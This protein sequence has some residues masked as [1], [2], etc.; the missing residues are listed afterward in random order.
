MRSPRSR[1]PLLAPLRRMVAAQHEHRARLNGGLARHQQ[2]WR[3]R[4]DKAPRIPVELTE[5]AHD[6]VCVAGEANA[7]NQSLPGAHPT[8]LVHWTACRVA[9]GERFEAVLAHRYPLAPSTP[10]HTGLELSILESGLPLAE[11]VRRWQAF[12][13][14]GDVVCS[15]GTFAVELARDARLPLPG[16]LLDL[17]KVTGDV[18]RISPG[19]VED[20][21][22][23]WSLDASAVG[24]GRAGLR[25][26]HLVRVARHLG[27]L[28]RP[29]ARL[30]SR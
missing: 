18:L 1:S 9:T 13:R 25:L 29:Q 15:W 24:A 30:R 26:G 2:R 21:T 19:S 14:P 22:R 3:S 11:V 16:A 20:A 5:R 6:L 7:W 28:R 4:P 23:R 10:F 12:L 17:R 8:E 27:A